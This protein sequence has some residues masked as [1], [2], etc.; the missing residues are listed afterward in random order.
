MTETLKLSKIVDTDFF[1]GE[2]DKLVRGHSLSYMDAIVYFCEKNE[3]EIETAAALIKGNFR[4][5]SHVQQEGET[6]NL[7]PRTAKLPI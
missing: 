1:Y 4:I 7:L 6:L 5:K 3:M 2:I